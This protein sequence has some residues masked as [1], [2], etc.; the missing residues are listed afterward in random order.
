MQTF[1]THILA[2]LVV[3]EGDNVNKAMTI[4]SYIISDP[5]PETVY[6]ER[7]F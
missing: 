2:S 6:I 3:R 5:V 7:G 4:I 1:F